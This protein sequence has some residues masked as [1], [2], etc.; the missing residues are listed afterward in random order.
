MYSL[1]RILISA[2]SCLLLITPSLRAADWPTWRYDA[3]RTA[4]ST[5]QL[6]AELHLQWVR[7]YA[8]P[9][10]A[11]PEDPRLLFDNSYEPIVLGTT[12]LLA[13]AQN[14]SLTAIDTQSGEKK[15]Q[16]FANAPIRFAPLAEGDRIYFGADDGCIYCLSA[17][18]GTL[19]WKFDAA[20]SARRVIGND[21]M[22]SI[23]PIRGGPVLT[24][25]KLYFTAGVWPFEGTFLYALDLEK[26]TPG[27]VP[28]SAAEVVTLTDMTPQGYL[29]AS[30]G[31]IFIPCGR[32]LAGCF[33]I[34]KG[35]MRPLA[36]D[37]RG[38]TDYHVTA[39]DRWLFHGQRVIDLATRKMLPIN[40]PR[41]VSD[42]SEFY[43]A[44]GENV[45]AADIL[46]Q[47]EPAPAKQGQSPPPPK[48]KAAWHVNARDIL[49]ALG[50]VSAARRVEGPLS[51]DIKAGTRVY[52]RY[53]NA[54]YAADAPSGGQ[55]A[56][57]S[58]AT[59]VEGDPSSLIAADGRLFVTT[60]EGKLFCYGGRPTVAKFYPASEQVTG[61]ADSTT[62]DAVLSLSE[63]I[64][65]PNG[66]CLIWGADD[67]ALIEQLL[68]QTEMQL[69]VIDSAAEK[70]S[71]LRKYFDARG[72]YGNR[73]TALL[74]DPLAMQLPPYFVNLLVC[75]DAEKLQALQESLP[76]ETLYEWLRPYG[77]TAALALDEAA[78]RDL[79]P[80]LNQLANAVV[81]RR[82]GMTVLRREGALQG[83]AN[84]SHEY[85]DPSNSLMSQDL[86][87]KLPLG[88]LWFGGPASDTR[89]FF[90]RHFWGPSLTVIDGRMF[91]Q[92][93]TTLAAVDI[94]TGKVLWEKTIEKGS[95]PGRRGNFYDGDHHTGYHFCAVEDGIYLTY[96]DR[97]L[98]IDPR[99]G[100]T[101]AEFKLPESTARWGRI[102]VWNDLLIASIF[103]TAKHEGRVPT[104]LVALDRKTGK[105][106]WDHTP[107][108]SCPTVAIG[109]D[110]V[111]Y[112]DGHI[113]ALYN[114]IGR[115]GNVPKTGK[116]R[117]LRALNAATGEEIWSHDTPLVITWLAYKQ[118]Q[119][120][121]VASNHEMIQARRGETG[122]TMWD[123]T[124]KSKGFLGH[125]ESRWDRVI[126]W[127]DRII[128]QRGPGV[129]YF[130]ETGEP[131]QME[132][133]ISGQPVNWEFTAHG[134]H[135]NYAIANEHM[136]TFRADSAGF[137]DMKN[138]TTGRLKGFRTGCRNSLIPAGGI[139]N[140]PNFG[141][142]CTCAY[143]LFTS[144]ALTHIPEMESWRYSA[145]GSPTGPVSRVGINLAAPGDRESESGTMWLDY[146][147]RGEHNYQLPN[148]AG[149]SPDVPV[150]LVAENPTWFR[151]HPGQL[152][153]SGERWVAASGVEGLDSLTVALGKDVR[154][155]R[156]YNVRLFFTE[157]EDLE[158]GERLFHV[159]LDGQQVLENLDIV[160]EAGGRNRVLIKEFENVPA[161]A[162]LQIEL[163]AI[164]GKT[165][166]S[167]VEVVASE[168]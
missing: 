158:P 10:P 2:V 124:A 117:T 9:R 82:S 4:S 5:E 67:I 167:G 97:C 121:L 116:Q 31:N 127:K 80:Q 166:L 39:S 94:Y 41:P 128:D 38:L 100:E 135:C 35:A 47:P 48:F 145:M 103:D 109:K 91:L 62:A 30:A 88:V 84:W 60:K 24:E 72:L 120:I 45:V 65:D 143:S 150:T 134:H 108:A 73:V 137:T 70:I 144:L 160:K 58:W 148:V 98:R 115:G 53:G 46:K 21:R 19:L 162:E 153:G 159:A 51:V 149:P 119:D 40:A 23:L 1:T 110:R 52:G 78:H 125:P 114:D 26:I 155:N 55:P 87:V 3:A 99:S 32:A 106:A 69:M 147:Q 136:M 66:Y 76:R 168:D 152:E 68:Q 165:L 107:E 28:D 89:F 102:R 90:D 43:I 11:W 71:V 161:G 157:P 129:Q 104:R 50:G 123:K 57:I 59:V 133:P 13:S 132:H 113:E 61:P 111:Y 146:P 56:R 44:Q 12:L 74:G 141:H 156:G 118:D 142:G 20:S 75:T 101:L 95:S 131:I 92:G 138:V 33:D 34:Q 122:E 29:V 86:R 64:P 140:A 25:G 37:S 49:H 105:I 17:A 154:E 112:F 14:D 42:G 36:Y 151:Q 77:G 139:L 16:F 63:N 93:H 163:T 79:G 54:I 130:L 15:W 164:Q 81:D 85:G 18:D 83:A 126:L 8:P 96:P 7:Q 22:I 27:D 6:P